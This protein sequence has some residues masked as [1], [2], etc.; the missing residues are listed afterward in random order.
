MR[1]DV[2][3]KVYDAESDE[4]VEPDAKLLSK[5]SDYVDEMK[6]PPVGHHI[7]DGYVVD[8]IG[9]ASGRTQ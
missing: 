7:I 3:F 2:T 4:L 5:I 8:F 9:K 1:H 6:V